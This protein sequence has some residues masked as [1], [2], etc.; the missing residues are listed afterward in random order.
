M[1][2][3][4]CIE[5]HWTS[6]VRA[7]LLEDGSPKPKRLRGAITLE[8][9][10]GQGVRQERMEKRKKNH[11]TSFLIAL[12][13]VSCT[14]RPVFIRRPRSVRSSFSFVFCSAPFSVSFSSSL[15]YLPS[16]SSFPNISYLFAVSRTSFS[17]P[18]LRSPPIILSFILS[19]FVLFHSF[20]LLSVF[21]L[22]FFLGCHSF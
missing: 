10:E 1:M 16:V 20:P 4:S 9:Q 7:A 21:V 13:S 5:V 15:L 11:L 22:F 17:S 18:S 14:G 2:R 12:H 8:R 19:S 3:L 6:Q